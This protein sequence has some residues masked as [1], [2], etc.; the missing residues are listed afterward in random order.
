[1][2][3]HTDGLMFIRGPARADRAD[4]YAI[5]VDRDG[6]RHII[7]EFFGRS[8]WDHEWPSAENARR[9]LACWYACESLPTEMLEQVGQIVI[10]SAIPYRLLI[11][12]R[13][14][15]LL[16]LEMVRD[17]NNDEPHIPDV[18]LR[19]IEA[20]IAKVTA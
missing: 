15:L 18:A 12:Q 9:F 2:S 7:A 3:T 1:M 17:A 11:D 13:N 16:A 10:P 14:A 19:C 5:E 6:E 8:D 4:D 20:A